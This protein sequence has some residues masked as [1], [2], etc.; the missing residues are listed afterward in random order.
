MNK[1]SFSK[2][3]LII[4]LAATISGCAGKLANQTYDDHRISDPL[5][6]IN[7]KLYV[8]NI[9]LDLAVVR[10]VAT[11]Y[12]YITPPFIR[13]RAS[14]FISNLTEPRNTINNLLQLKLKRSFTS[15]ARFTVNSTLGIVG[16][17]DI[18]GRSGVPSKPE[19]FGQTLGYWGFKPGAYIYLPLFGPSSVRDSIG[20]VGDF[21]MFSPQS[22]VNST[23]AQV[24]TTV[25]T[26]VETRA[27]LLRFDPILKR[28]V[29]IYNFLKNG[30]EQ[31]RVNQIFD[32]NPPEQEEDF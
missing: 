26:V 31:T 14:S 12:D 9:F 15:L 16:L 21:L 1:F 3:I 17:F 5:K 29:N 7:E 30:Y 11:G 22:L 25:L 32:G 13:N 4:T 28:Q 27:D 2:H 24:G 23:S 18:M 6:P 20:R 8:A 19:D 10:P